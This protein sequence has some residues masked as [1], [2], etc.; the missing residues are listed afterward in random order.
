M[1]L[2]ASRAL[3]ASEARDYVVPDDVKRL[4][5]PIPGHR[6]IVAADAA[7]NGRTAAAILSELMQEVPVPVRG[8]T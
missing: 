7:M 1:L 4:M 3:A 6:V 5:V 8:K 2:R